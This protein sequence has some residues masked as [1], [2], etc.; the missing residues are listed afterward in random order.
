MNLRP[1][2]IAFGV[3][4]VA[5]VVALYLLW[6]KN[7]PLGLPL[8]ETCE[9]GDADCRDKLPDVCVADCIEC[10]TTLNRCLYRLKDSPSCMCVPGET[11]PCT[12]ALGQPGQ[13]TCEQI[14]PV[15]DDHAD[16]GA[17]TAL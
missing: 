10:H 9:A 8:V 4:I 14:G 17:C 6:I 5:L 1:I 12:T 7:P 2:V 11:K 16:W 13:H 15:S 3:V